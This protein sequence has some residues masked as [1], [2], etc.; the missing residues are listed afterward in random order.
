MQSLKIVT[1]LFAVVPWSL[2]VGTLAYLI[3]NRKKKE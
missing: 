3:A 1:F 2:V